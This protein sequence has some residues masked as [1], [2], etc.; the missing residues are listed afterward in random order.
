M[1]ERYPDLEWQLHLTQFDS[2]GALI[3]DPTNAIDRFKAQ[4]P[5]DEV[6]VIYVHGIGDGYPFLALENWLAAAPKRQLIFL[7]GDL[8]ALHRLKSTA[9]GHRL[10]EHSQV[11]LRF[12][13][14][15]I[16]NVLEECARDFPSEKIFVA[17]Y[18]KK[19]A[20]FSSIQLALLRKTVLWNSVV[21]ETLSS[22]LLHRNILSNFWKLPR[23]FY[24][25]ATRGA[26]AGRPAVICGAG[27]SLNDVADQ[28]RAVQDRAL[29]IGCGSALSA[30]SHL[31]VRPHVGIA[32][33]PNAREKECLKGCQYKDLPLIYGNRLYPEVFELFDGPYGYIRSPT[34]SALERAIED[35]LGFSEDEIGLDLGRE[36]LSVTTLALSLACFWGC[37]PI[38][39]AGVDLAYAGKSHYAKGVP[40]QLTK[41]SR[42]IRVGE[43]LI[44]RKGTEGKRVATLVKWMMEQQTIDAYTHLYPKTTFINAT[45]K[46]LGFLSIPHQSWEEIERL[47]AHAKPIHADLKKMISENPTLVCSE[48]LKETLDRIHVSFQ[49]CQILAQQLHE[50]PEESGKAILYHHE[51]LEEIAYQLALGPALIAFEKACLL[52]AEIPS[53]QYRY[54]F[55]QQ[56]IQEYLKLFS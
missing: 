46:G 45:G 2:T 30:L 47:I 12:L 19:K 10:V 22:H 36:A 23:S 42:E 3:P 44:Y 31:Q 55:L 54:Q 6:N 18:G 56:I 1:F 5:L 11:H 39:L 16:D 9:W 33:D 4:L 41:K 51:L 28:L 38:I 40:V 17:A 34:A 49:K 48:K 50:E 15:P 35:D 53:H 20:N 43:Q 7:E 29:L 52:N 8:Y 37:S 26:F 13:T 21:S 14:P 32:I 24:V 27:P 25:N